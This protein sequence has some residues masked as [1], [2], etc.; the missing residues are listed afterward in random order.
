MWIH[1]KVYLIYTWN[2]YIQNAYRNSS[3]LYVIKAFEIAH[4]EEKVYADEIKLEKPFYLYKL[5]NYFFL[6]PS[7]RKEIMHFSKPPPSTMKVC[8]LLPIIVPN[9]MNMF[10]LLFKHPST[11]VTSKQHKSRWLCL[12]RW[13]ITFSNLLTILNVCLNWI[14]TNFVSLERN[15]ELF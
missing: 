1:V 15:N 10:E 7:N 11:S 3:I 13:M 12:S 14:A 5:H 4:F 2:I 8:S 9:G 6:W